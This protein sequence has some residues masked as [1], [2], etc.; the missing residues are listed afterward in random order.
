M[1]MKRALLAALAFLVMGSHSSA[2]DPDRAKDDRAR[3]RIAGMVM[4]EVLNVSD[5]LPRDLMDQARCVIVMPSVYKA[6]FTVGGNLGRGAMVCRS[7]RNFTGPWGA[8]VMMALEGGSFGDQAG[9]DVSDFVLLLMNDRGVRNLMLS[10]VKLG[11]RVSI[12]AGPL[13]RDA[14][15][16]NNGYERSEILS[17]SRTRGVLAG[18]SLEGSTLRPDDRANRNLYEWPVSAQAILDGAGVKAPPE[19]RVL[20]AMLQN[21]SPRRQVERS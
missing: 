6:A 21:A 5:D 19:A 4:R 12:A 17:Y 9:G 16:D 7:G 18:V 15:A 1:K 10:K 3:L 11:G 2:S 8:P 13:G 14:A 20:I